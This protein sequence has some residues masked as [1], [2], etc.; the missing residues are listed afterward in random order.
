MDAVQLWIFILYTIIKKKNWVPKVCSKKYFQIVISGL[1][2]TF[3]RIAHVPT[4]FNAIFADEIFIKFRVPFD[5]SCLAALLF[6]GDDLSPTIERC[7]V[8]VCVN[9]ECKIFP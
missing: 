1:I 2:A 3:V 5:A 7:T 9:C 8:C 4:V 6:R